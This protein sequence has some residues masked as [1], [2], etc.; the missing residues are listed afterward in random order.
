MV[1]HRK[2]DKINCCYVPG[3]YTELNYVKK[4]VKRGRL[5]IPMLDQMRSIPNE[6]HWQKYVRRL[7]SRTPSVGCVR[8]CEREREWKRILDVAYRHLKL[9][10][11]KLERKNRLRTYCT[12]SNDDGPQWAEERERERERPFVIY[13]NWRGILSDAFRSF[14]AFNHRIASLRIAMHRTGKSL[15]QWKWVGRNGSEN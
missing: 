15:A 11:W 5:P 10:N 9:Q 1:A 8:V 6:R 4:Y 7:F 14:K 13:L 3:A 2:T 12:Y